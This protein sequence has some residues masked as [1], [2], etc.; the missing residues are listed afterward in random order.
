TTQFPYKLFWWE[1]P[2]GSRILTYFP[3]D[4]VNDI[5]PVRISQ[6][7][8]EYVPKTGIPEILHLYGIGD[9]GG[10]PTRSMLDSALRWQDRPNSFPKLTFGTVQS[11][12]DDVEKQLPQASVPVWDN[13][14][15][16]QYHR[17]VLTTQ[18]ETKKRIRQ[19]EELLLNAEKFSSLA[20]LHGMTYPQEELNNDW[21][22]VL[23]DQFHDVMPGSG[24]AINY[25]DAARDQAVVGLSGKKILSG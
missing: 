2:D 10:G 13:E 18:S 14:L 3:H 20:M 22:K 6:D 15:Y 5:D 24:I 25:V 9:H 21:K 12:F 23:F 16:L 8:A 17:G 1:S 19:S 4:Y 7:V 11:F